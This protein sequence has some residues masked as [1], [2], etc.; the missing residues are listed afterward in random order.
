MVNYNN[1]YF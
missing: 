1:R